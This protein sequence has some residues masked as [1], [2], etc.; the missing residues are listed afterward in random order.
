[1]QP[2]ACFRLNPILLAVSLLFVTACGGGG[3]G[4]VISGDT[5]STSSTSTTSTSTTSTTS[6]TLAPTSGNNPVLTGVA[7]TGAPLSG[8]TVKV[9]DATGTA[10]QLLDAT[11]TEVSSGTTTPAD[12]TYRLVL[13]TSSLKTPLFIQATGTDAAGTPVVL[14][15][16]LQTGT[17]PL[18][19]HLTPATNAVVSQVL[20][21][22]PKPVFLNAASNASAI[23]LLGNATIVTNA[24]DLVKTIIKANLTDVKITDTKKLD[25]FQDAAF[26]ANKTG[27]DAA[28]EGLR[29]Q[30]I[31]DASGKEQL[32]FS[33]KFAPLGSAEVI[34]DLATAK[35]ELTKTSGGSVV[36]AITSTLKITT[37]PTTIF[38]NLSLLDNLSIALNKLIANGAVAA[39]FNPF[40]MAPTA[41]YT[42]QYNGRNLTALADKL[43]GYAV[44]NYQLRKFQVTGCAD[45]PVT[46]KAC[47]KVLVSSLVTDINGQR[48]DV[49]SDAVTYSKTTTPN[50]LFIGNDASSDFSVYPVAYA[51][52]G[53][54]GILATGAAANPGYGVQVIISAAAGDVTNRTVQIPSGYSIP[55]ADCGMAYFCVQ[56]ASAATPTATGELAD[57]LPQQLSIGAIGNL[58][59]ANGAKYLISVAGSSTSF[60][61]YLPTNVLSDFSNAPFPMLDG[62]T[63]EKPLTTADFSGTAQLSLSWA[64]WAAANPNS[65]IISARALISSSAAPPVIKDAVIPLMPV[66]SVKIPSFGTVATATSYQVWLGAQDNLGRRYYSKYTSSP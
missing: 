20:G 13:A 3:G 53:F 41:T 58:D 2:A 57:V 47:T 36:K 26:S 60:P 14:H 65:K 19:A 63:S 45:Y 50:W 35:A 46:A 11:G 4:D 39:D 27:L 51:T 49:L 10:V 55:F 16:L 15:S 5:S 42:Y 7:A 54:D 31:K 34:L 43:A 1:M 21:T 52:Y 12:G 6:T 40:V 25:F 17:L 61:A 38:A 8:A 66:T 28:L 23:A 44:Q 48:V 62:V 64:T 18:I 37:S 59:S 24:S 22:D 32:Q 29:I 30:I 33:N 9:V 56:T